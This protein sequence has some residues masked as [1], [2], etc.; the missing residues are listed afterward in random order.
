MM[1]AASKSAKSLPKIFKPR[2]AQILSWYKFKRG[3]PCPDKPHHLD[4][5]FKEPLEKIYDRLSEPALL[6]ICLPGYTQNA[7]V[8][9]MSCME[10]REL[11]W[12][13]PVLLCTSVVVQHKKN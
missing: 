4:S 3:L 10:E 13:H 5:V 6:I 2:K 8:P 1:L 11:S 12:L 7:N 9:S